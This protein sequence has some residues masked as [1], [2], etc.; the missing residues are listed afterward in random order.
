[1]P[2][3]TKEK[4]PICP[5]CGSTDFGFQRWIYVNKSGGNI[6]QYSATCKNCN[7][8]ILVKR[9][10]YIYDELENQEWQKSKEFKRR[11][12]FENFSKNDKSYLAK[13]RLEQKILNKNS[14][15]KPTLKKTN[16][17]WL[18]ENK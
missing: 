6:Y 7:N 4:K 16:G 15:K 8:R 9:N 3:Y 14:G 2:I 1:M 10:E 11:E 13:R 5:K 17:K 18:K 12:V